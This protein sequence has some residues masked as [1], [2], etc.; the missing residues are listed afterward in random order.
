MRQVYKLPLVLEPQPEGGYTITCPLL[1][2]LIT[3]A[4]T[5]EEV[6]PNVTD[7]VTALLEAY[8][9]MNL[10]LPDILQPVSQNA[11]LLAETLIQ[12]EAA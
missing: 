10:P 8:Q 4:D 3:E 2:N 12:M 7:A 5:L 9:E 11:P 6:I 1:P